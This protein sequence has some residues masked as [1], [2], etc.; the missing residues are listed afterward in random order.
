MR[1]TKMPSNL[2]TGLGAFDRVFADGLQV[3]AIASVADER[4]VALLELTLQRGEDRALI[5]RVLLRRLM[6]AADHGKC[7]RRCCGSSW[8][9]GHGHQRQHKTFD[10]HTFR[11][12]PRKTA[13]SGPQ[14]HLEPANAVSH[15]LL[16]FGRPGNPE[17]R[18]PSRSVRGS[19]GEAR[20]LQKGC[21]VCDGTVRGCLTPAK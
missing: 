5:G 9:C 16:P 2:L 20:Q 3:A 12:M 10:S 19:S 1:T 4:L 11:R 6:V 18:L 14:R 13:R 7:S 17:N 21:S 8:N 15:P